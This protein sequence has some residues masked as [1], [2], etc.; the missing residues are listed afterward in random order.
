[1]QKAIDN[2]K[3]YYDNIKDYGKGKM[4]KKARTYLSD[5]NYDDEY[6]LIKNSDKLPSGVV[7]NKPK[8]IPENYY[9]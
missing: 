1:M 8:P 9:E 2:I 3:P 4:P 6:D 7:L 5:K